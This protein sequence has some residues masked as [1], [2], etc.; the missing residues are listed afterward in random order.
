ML[1]K[2]SY[3]LHTNLKIYKT[4][5]IVK[6]NTFFIKKKSKFKGAH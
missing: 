1:N 4:K 2:M 3:K 5:Q 6:N